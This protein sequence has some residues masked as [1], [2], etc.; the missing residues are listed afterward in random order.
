[1]I[2]RE[3]PPKEAN[4]SQTFA[5]QG[6][7]K[8]QTRCHPILSASLARRIST[9]RHREFQPRAASLSLL[10]YPRH[11]HRTTP[12]LTNL[13]I[14]PVSIPRDPSVNP[15]RDPMHTGN[16]QHPSHKIP[17]R[18]KQSNPRPCIHSAKHASASVH[19]LH[20][21]HG[22]IRVHLREAS[23]NGEIVQ[24]EKF[25][26]AMR[27]KSAC[28]FRARRAKRAMAVVKDYQLSHIPSPSKNARR[29]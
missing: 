3:E 2:A 5:V 28:T 1:M 22:Q 14:P 10:P 21:A 16:E 4:S 11:M 25:N 7:L 27:V 26:A 20:P 23:R 13:P 9:A 6:E 24:V 19:G 29:S 17:A 8:A 12:V 15:R 18:Q